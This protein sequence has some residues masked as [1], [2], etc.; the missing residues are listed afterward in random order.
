[1]Q[2]E[3]ITEKYTLTKEG[4]NYTLE[5]G[6]VKNAEDKSIELLITGIEDSSLFSIEKTCGCT[7]TEKTN[8][9]VNTQKVKITYKQCDPSFAKVMEIKYRNVKIG[10]IKIKGKC[11][12]Q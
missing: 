11:S 12:H 10:I 5:L 3:K 6:N 4:T 9:D 8:I 1:M 7:A 2:I